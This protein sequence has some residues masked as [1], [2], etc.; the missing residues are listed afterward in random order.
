MNREI[1]FRAISP[2]NTNEPKVM[3][4]YNLC[5][6]DDISSL[7]TD[8]WDIDRIM[9][10]TGVKDIK[11]KEVYEGD[12]ITAFSGRKYIVKFDNLSFSLYSVEYKDMRWG[13]LFRLFEMNEDF[14]VTGNIYENADMLN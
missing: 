14:E 10:F 7:S 9:Q 2:V 6:I 12:I 11:G 5:K 4:Y 1:K 13:N 3:R 8:D